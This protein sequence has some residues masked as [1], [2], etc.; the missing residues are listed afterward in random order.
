VSE[1][2]LGLLDRLSD[3]S[4]YVPVGV[5]HAAIGVRSALQ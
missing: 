4:G 3:L 2:E 1:A 5:C